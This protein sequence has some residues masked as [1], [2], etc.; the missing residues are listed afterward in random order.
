MLKRLIDI[1]LS[2]AMLAVAAPMLVMPG[3]LLFVESL[4]GHPLYVDRYVLY[5]E[6]GAAMLAGAGVY[7]TGRWL[8]G[9][10]SRRS[11]GAESHGATQTLRTGRGRP[12]STG[13]RGAPNQRSG[14][15]TIVSS[16]CCTIWT[17]SSRPAIG[18]IGDARAR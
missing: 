6:A 4:V 10:L 13:N 12:R 14:G 7:R 9:A 1:L 15:A 8:A 3:G 17:W 2:A 18:S 5:G 16:R 11:G